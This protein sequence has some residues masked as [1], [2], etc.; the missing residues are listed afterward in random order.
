MRLALALFLDTA[1]SWRRFSSPS[2][3]VEA[4]VGAG[5]R[6]GVLGQERTLRVDAAYGLR[7]GEY[8]LSVGWELPWPRWH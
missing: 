6:L 4:D 2:S 5:L 8:A 7:D 1:K 3:A